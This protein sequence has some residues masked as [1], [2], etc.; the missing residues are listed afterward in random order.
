M[1]IEQIREMEVKSFLLNNIEYLEMYGYITLVQ[2]FFGKDF[3][4]DQKITKIY[5][6][7]KNNS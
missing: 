2:S 3:I 6:M 5:N 7:I 4:N 1:S